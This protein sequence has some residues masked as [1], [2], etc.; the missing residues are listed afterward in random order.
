MTLL[1]VRNVTKRY[2]G[3]AAVDDVSFGID[4]GEAVGLIGSN[5]AGK[6]TLFKMIAGELAMTSGTITFDGRQMTSGRRQLADL[7]RRP[8]A[9]LQRLPSRPDGRARLGI[10]RTFQL[11]EMFGGLTVLD[12]VLVSLQAHTGR[13]GPLRDLSGHGGTTDEEAARCEAT[14]ELCGLAGLGRAPVEALSLGQ[15]R[16]VELARA[17]VAVPRILLA[18]E[19]SSGLDTHEAGELAAVIRRVR[20][21]TRLAVLLVEHDLATVEA[22]AERVIA[23]DAGRVISAGTF[24]EVLHD[25]LVVASWL[26]KPA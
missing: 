8:E 17:L 3:N 13:Q 9:G 1:E 24:D 10:A 21:E 7:T 19:P 26:G 15:R 12:H 6:T 20:A 14:I 4:E 18:D 11:V 2:G 25:P 23:M 5:G 22:V 16:A